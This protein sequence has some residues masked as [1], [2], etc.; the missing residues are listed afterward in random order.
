MWRN[1]RSLVL[2]VLLLCSVLN[3]SS[4]RANGEGVEKQLQSEYQG[5]VLTLRHF[6]SAE[7]LR[8][9]LDGTLVGEAAV[10]PWAVDG[11]LLVKSIHLRGRILN[12]EGR[13]LFMFFDPDTKGF[14]DIL[15]V[16]KDEK[17]AKQFAAIRNR[18]LSKQ[19]IDQQ[20]V[21]IEIELVSETPD[22]KEISSATNAIFLAPGESFA[23]VV[24]SFWHSYFARQEGRREKEPSFDEPVYRAEQGEASAPHAVYMPDPEYS[25]LAGYSGEGERRFRREGERHSGVKVNSSR[26]EATLA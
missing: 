13:R 9:G 20:R 16:R 3:A 10:G 14:R 17:V 25:E 5:K 21:E 1:S 7:H 18:D 4:V 24:P 11:Q 22:S 15:T 8:F 12:I 19:L 6:Y 2:A 23:D 26:S